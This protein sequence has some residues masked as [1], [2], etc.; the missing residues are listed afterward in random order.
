MSG[1]CRSSCQGLCFRRGCTPVKSTRVRSC[2]ARLFEPSRAAPQPGPPIVWFENVVNRPGC[3]AGRIEA[4]PPVSVVDDDEEPATKRRLAP[5]DPLNRA[6]ID[7]ARHPGS[8]ATPRR[9]RWYSSRAGVDI[10]FNSRYR[11]PTR[12]LLSVGL[13]AGPL[14]VLALQVN[15]QRVE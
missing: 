13:Q 6:E 1:P 3:M 4:G 11:P 5:H 7:P 10:A 9:A 2:S 8:R 14:D 15:R 12:R